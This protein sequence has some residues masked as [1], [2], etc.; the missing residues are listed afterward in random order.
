MSDCLPED[1]IIEILQN[2]PVKFFIQCTSVCKLWYS[3]IKTPHFISAQIAKTSTHPTPLLLSH[4]QDHRYSLVFENEKLKEYMPLHFPFKYDS[5]F[6][7][8]S[9]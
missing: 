7:R 4:F 9:E 2:L 1:V 6:F 8:S 5:R 3:L